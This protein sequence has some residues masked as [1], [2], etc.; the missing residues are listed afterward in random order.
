MT[1]LPAHS[2]STSQLVEFLA[3]LAE[4]SD[5][6]TA[7][8]VAVERVLESLDAEVGLLFNGQGVAAVVGLDPAVF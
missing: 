1:N 7:Q 4:Q 8:Q 6:L 5:E 2:W 3:V